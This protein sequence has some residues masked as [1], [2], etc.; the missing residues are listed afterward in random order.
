M[1]TEINTSWALF[2]LESG[3]WKQRFSFCLK[4]GRNVYYKNTCIPNETKI[5]TKSWI[6]RMPVI[7][8]GLEGQTGTK[9][10][11]GLQQ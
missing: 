1:S 2:Y 3:Y 11:Q 4:Q 9:Q 5:L 6:D 8:T 10:F 7:Q